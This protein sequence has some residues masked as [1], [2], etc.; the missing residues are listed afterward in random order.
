MQALA[1]AGGFS[2]LEYLGLEE[3]SIGE[4]GRQ[5]VRESPHLRNVQ[6]FLLDRRLLAIEEEEAGAA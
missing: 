4:R 5:A 1:E 6:G 3:D 2:G